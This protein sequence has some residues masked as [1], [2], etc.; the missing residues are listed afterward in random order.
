MPHCTAP[1]TTTLLPRLDKDDA[2]IVVADKSEVAKFE[3][4]VRFITVPAGS[5]TELPFE[6]LFT[7]TCPT[8]VTCGVLSAVAL[9]GMA[10]EE[11][12]KSVGRFAASETTGAGGLI[13]MVSEVF[14][15]PSF[16]AVM[17]TVPTMLG[18][19]KP[20]EV[21]LPLPV[22]GTTVQ[23]KI[24]VCGIML[25]CTSNP[26]AVSCTFLPQSTVW[27]SGGEILT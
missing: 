17:V 6:S 18:V 3:L 11:L 21:T 13:S 5:T 4:S 20:F 2:D 9:S 22:P 16:D 23:V 7:V 12:E 19:N 14:V 26:W 10:N 24:G 8:L 27:G 25:L 15:L 1:S